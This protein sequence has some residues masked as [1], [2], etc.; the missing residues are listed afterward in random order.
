M[1][2]LSGKELNAWNELDQQEGNFDGETETY[3]GVRGDL[4]YMLYCNSKFKIYPR[5]P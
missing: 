4:S 5:Q 1:V 2:I 3:I